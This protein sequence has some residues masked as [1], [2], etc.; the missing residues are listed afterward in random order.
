MYATQVVMP[1]SLG[2]VLAFL[3]KAEMLTQGVNAE[4]CPRGPAAIS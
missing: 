4:I 3:I 2:N 1:I